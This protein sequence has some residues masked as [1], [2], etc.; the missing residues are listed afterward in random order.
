[1]PTQ[2]KTSPESALKCRVR[3]EG[4]EVFL[5]APSGHDV[6][7]YRRRLEQIVRLFT[8]ASLNVWGEGAH[9]QVKLAVKTPEGRDS[10]VGLAAVIV[11]LNL[12]EAAESAGQGFPSAGW[13]AEQLGDRLDFRDEMLCVRR[14]PEPNAAMLA[15][16]RERLALGAALGT[17]GA[18]CNRGFHRLAPRTR[19][20][21][22]GKRKPG[23]ASA[24]SVSPI[25]KANVMQTRAN[26]N[27][28]DVLVMLP[29]GESLNDA[30]REVIFLFFSRRRFFARLPYPGEADR[31]VVVYGGNF[32]SPNHVIIE[33]LPDGMFRK[34]FAFVDAGPLM[35]DYLCASDA[36][37]DAR[38]Y[39]AVAS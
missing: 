5:N 23:V 18:R 6:R 32:H 28:D 2:P 38:C 14:K 7:L 25:Q 31:V 1:M 3:S 27:D 12:I 17:L 16:L 39:P 8:A 34:W 30:E 35:A 21:R 15:N 20:R 4:D 33:R 10:S 37:W 19:D 26:D 13:T 36:T 24:G 22:L 9:F 29:P 11:A